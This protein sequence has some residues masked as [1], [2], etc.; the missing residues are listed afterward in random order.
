MVACPATGPDRHLAG[1]AA[2]HPRRP[3]VP[4]TVPAARLAHRPGPGSS[5]PRGLPAAELVDRRRGPPG[6]H[7]L[8]PGGVAPGRHRPQPAGGPAVARPAGTGR[9]ILRRL[10]PR[11]PARVVGPGA[12]GRGRRHR[13]VGRPRRRRSVRAAG[14]TDGARGVG[15]GSGRCR[16]LLSTDPPVIESFPAAERAV[17][18]LFDAAAGKP[19]VVLTG[20]GLSTESGIPDYRGVTGRARPASPMTY[21]EFTGSAPARRTYWARSHIGWRTI[22]E[23]EPNEGHHAVAQL[24]QSGRVG[25]VITQ[26]VDGLHQAGGAGEVIEL[27]GNLDRVVCLDCGDTSSRAELEARLTAANPYLDDMI[28]AARTDVKPDGDVDLSEDLVERFQVRGCVACGGRLKPDVVFFGESVPKSLVKHCFSRVET[29]GAVVMSGYRFVRRAGK[30]GIPVG[31]VNQGQTRGDHE[32]HFRVNLPLGQT[33]CRIV[34]HF[35]RS[36]APPPGHRP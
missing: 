8:R 10:R 20:A 17:A 31:I 33:L 11:P 14:A 35:A 26:N 21:Q 16:P 19:V 18:E 32:A 1:P 4:D 12:A 6:G 27:H 28:H 9:G 22:A 23:A 25:T 24:Q 15:A 29:S 3:G 5:H 30:L 13:R 2:S 34:A 7:R 36:A